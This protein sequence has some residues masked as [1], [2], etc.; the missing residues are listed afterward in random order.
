MEAAVKFS[1]ASQDY[2]EGLEFNN[3]PSLGQA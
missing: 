1:V 3:A 2:G